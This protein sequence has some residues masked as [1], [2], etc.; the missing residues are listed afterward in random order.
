M[1]LTQAQKDAATQAVNRLREP[2]SVKVSKRAKSS[3]GQAIVELSYNS[4][5][6]GTLVVVVSQDLTAK[7]VKK[8][9]NGEKEVAA[10]GATAFEAADSYVFSV[11]GRR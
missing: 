5:E 7:I 6:E 10:T 4:G 3:T 2:L 8:S 9:A 1:E 11:F